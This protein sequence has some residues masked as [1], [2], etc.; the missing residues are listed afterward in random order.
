MIEEVIDALKSTLVTNLPAMLDTID[1]EKNDS[2]KLCDI[3]TD[4]IFTYS[5]QLL[6]TVPAIV[7]LAQ[8]S[9]P[10][11]LISGESA[12]V[13]DFTHSIYVICVVGDTDKARLTRKSFRY[14]DALWR[15]IKNNYKLGMQQVID[16]TITDH[17]HSN[18]YKKKGA[19]RKDFYLK[20]NIK[21]RI[22]V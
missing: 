9:P 15:V 1:A 22:T 7:L 2:I 14:L 4:L 17:A 20:L 10:D 6:P 3:P 18:Q 5:E 11:G 12:K 8:G 21:E 13:N 19:Y 16:T